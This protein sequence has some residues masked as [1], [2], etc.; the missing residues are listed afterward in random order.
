MSTL[1]SAPRLRSTLAGAL[2][3]G[4]LVHHLAWPLAAAV[5][6]SAALMHGGGDR[7]LAD[8]AFHLEGGRWVLR[9]HWLTSGV[10]HRG[11][12]WLSALAA[13]AVLGLYL[14]ALRDRQW[15]SLRQPLL[16]LLLAAAL[17]SASVSLLKSVTHVDCPWDL[18]GYGGTREPRELFASPAVGAP[19]GVCYPAGHASAG[20]AWVS[21]YFAAMLWRPRWRWWGLGIGIGAG[22]LFGIGQQLRGAHF[23]SHDIAA[24]AVCW[25]VALVLFVAFHSRASRTTV[26][27]SAA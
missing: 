3:R 17:G 22:L 27:G 26:I 21:L 20:Y 18:A 5:L 7:W 8:V 24:L 19:R 4:F 14:R 6:A 11:G 12:K 9:D 13:A 2:P 10:I 25:L 16:Y 23:L 1:L 15:A